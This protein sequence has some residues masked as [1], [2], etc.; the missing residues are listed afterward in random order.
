MTCQQAKDYLVL[1]EYSELSFEEEESLESHVAACPECQAERLRLQDLSGALA[2]CEEEL[3]AGLLARSRR[4]FAS[5][6]ERERKLER[7]PWR[8]FWRRWVVNPPMWLRPV[9]ALTMLAAGFFGARVISTTPA[10][11][12][13]ASLV[14]GQAPAV[15]TR[16]RLVNPDA[17]GRVRLLLEETRQR[18]LSGE[19]DNQEIRRLL[20]AAASDPADP[21]LRV[22]SIDLLKAHTSDDEVRRALLDALRGDPNSGVRL[23]AIEGLR[24]YA[25]DPETRR[26][27]AAVL[28]HD[29]NPGVRT[30]AIDLL[31]QSKE[32]DVAGVL[33]ELVR[34]EENNYVRS[35][36]QRALNEMKAS[37]GTF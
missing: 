30:Q 13:V 20:L 2:R 37:V 36:S 24:P 14:S 32:A 16:V 17:N 29:D 26:V 5:A 6:L 23:K 11:A 21:G 7:R 22:E 8:E 35:R 15:A 12:P 3:P 33:Q 19:L 28:L 10:M 31:V 34:R 25:R 4:E 9:G 1:A 27:L 18:E